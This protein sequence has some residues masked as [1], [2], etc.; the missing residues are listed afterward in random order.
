MASADWMPRNL[1]RRVE[2][3]FP[4]EDKDCAAR[5]R[6]ILDVQLADTLK[7]H[8]LKED[9]RY[10]K[11]DKRGKALIGAQATLMKEAMEAA[12]DKSDPKQSRVFTPAE[13]NREN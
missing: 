6:H 7:A 1:D 5:A 12:K 13:K 11:I 8:E 2:I 4:L 9:D 10:E 3:L